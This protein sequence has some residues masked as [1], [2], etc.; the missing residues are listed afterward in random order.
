MIGAMIES[1]EY[2]AF[3]NDLLERAA[4]VP[5]SVQH[6]KRAEAWRAG[7][8]SVWR[9]QMTPEEAAKNVAAR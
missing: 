4:P 3:L 9:G 5:S 7:I 1:R 8:S 6:P 2:S